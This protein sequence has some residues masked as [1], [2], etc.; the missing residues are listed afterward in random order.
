MN[1]DRRKKDWQNDWDDRSASDRRN[2][3]GYG[4]S[5]PGDDKSDA[6]REQEDPE[7]WDGQ[8]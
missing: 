4:N 1:Q 5:S 3:A 6:E 2:N 8:S 7:R